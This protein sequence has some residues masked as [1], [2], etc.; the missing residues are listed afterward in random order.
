MSSTGLKTFMIAVAAN[1][2]ALLIVE[3]WR[4]RAR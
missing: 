3:W 4:G 2:A 1:L